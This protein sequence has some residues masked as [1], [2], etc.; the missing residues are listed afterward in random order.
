MERFDNQEKPSPASGPRLARLAIVAVL[1]LTVSIMTTVMVAA[2]TQGKASDSIA[3]V[4]VSA[5]RS[6]DMNLN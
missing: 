4:S 5:G 3:I 6:I 1:T 2:G